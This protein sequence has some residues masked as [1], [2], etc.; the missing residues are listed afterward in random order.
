MDMFWLLVRLV[1]ALLLVA[2]ML[3]MAARIAGKRGLGAAADAVEVL[4]R[5]PLSRTSAICVVR[6]ADRVL[7]L[8]SSEQQITLLGETD[9]EAIEFSTLAA[10]A[11]TEAA[12][13]TGLGVG[14]IGTV[15]AVRSFNRLTTGSVMDPAQWR[16][17]VNGIRDRTVRRR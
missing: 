10:H 2:G 16:A 6:V 4:A 11:R 7:I 14:T 17:A 3:W 1:L 15:G 5:Q 9:L 8:G 12:G 13:S